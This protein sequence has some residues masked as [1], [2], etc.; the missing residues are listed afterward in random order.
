METGAAEFGTGLL[1]D[2]T[3]ETGLETRTHVLWP[4]AAPPFFLLEETA[5]LEVVAQVLPDTTTLLTGTVRIE[6]NGEARRYFNS[7]AATSGDGRV[8]AAFTIRL[9]WCRSGSICR[10]TNCLSRWA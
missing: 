8:A 6:R 4:E 5:G 1:I 9:I 7:M 10:S 3:R 2:L